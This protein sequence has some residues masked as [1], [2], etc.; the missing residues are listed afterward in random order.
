MDAFTL[1]VQESCESWSSPAPVDPA[2]AANPSAENPPPEASACPTPASSPRVSIPDVSQL[3]RRLVDQSTPV[4]CASTVRADRTLTAENIEPDL[5]DGGDRAVPEARAVPNARSQTDA[6]TLPQ[7]TPPSTPVPSKASESTA[8][9]AP[10]Q[11]RATVL[12]SSLL[13]ILPHFALAAIYV[14]VHSM[15]FLVQVCEMYT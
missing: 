2:P 8:P 5:S 9:A 7:G 11:T 4:D 10:K 6:Q 13:D 1:T 12:D 14:I 3:R 15:I